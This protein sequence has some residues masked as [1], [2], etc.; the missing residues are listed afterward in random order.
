MNQFDISK[1]S[2]SYDEA[3]KKRASAV[4]KRIKIFLC[5]IVPPVLSYFFGAFIYASFDVVEWTQNGRI[6]IVFV[7]VVLWWLSSFMIIFS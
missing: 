3:E 1:L 4:I 2:N 5:V 7:S 6:N